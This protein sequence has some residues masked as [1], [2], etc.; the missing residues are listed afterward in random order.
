MSAVQLMELYEKD[1]FMKQ[2]VP[3]IKEKSKYPL[4]VDSNDIICSLPP[5]INGEH[6]KVLFIIS[7]KS[8][9]FLVDYPEDKKCFYRSYWYRE[10]PIIS[11]LIEDFST[12]RT[13]TTV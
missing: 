11:T 9:L 3:I 10:G 2:F 8:L 6:S 13:F 5:I 12:L 7:F 4:I 1:N